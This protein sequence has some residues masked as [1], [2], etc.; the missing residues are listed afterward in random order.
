MGRVTSSAPILPAIARTAAC[1]RDQLGCSEFCS[2]EDDRVIVHA[3]VR[4]HGFGPVAVTRGV[5]E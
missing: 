4:V 2:G 5:A 1:R 3:G